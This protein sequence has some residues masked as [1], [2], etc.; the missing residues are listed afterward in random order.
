MYIII[1]VVVL[2][3]GGGIFVLASKKSAPAA[4]TTQGQMEDVVQAINPDDLGLVVKTNPNTVTPGVRFYFTKTGDIK[5]I[6]YQLQYT[7]TV[8]D[9]EGEHSVGEQ[10]TGE[11]K[12]LSDGTFGIKD[13]RDFGTCSSGRC[14]YDV[15]ITDTKLVFK[16]VKNDGTVYEAEKSFSL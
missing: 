16:I 1:A 9:S 10:L 8:N 12:E 5:L 13:Y 4:Q 11:A 15:G 6:E 3:L 7:H 14:R 2:V